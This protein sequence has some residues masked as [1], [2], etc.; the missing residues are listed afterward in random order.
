MKQDVSYK[1]LASFLWSN[2]RKY[3]KIVLGKGVKFIRAKHLIYYT[4]GGII[5]TEGSD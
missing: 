5:D 1:R 2:W 4:P 3:Q